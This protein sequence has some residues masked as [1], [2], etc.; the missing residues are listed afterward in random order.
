[1]S[2]SKSCGGASGDRHG[3]GIELREAT[4]VTMSSSTTGLPVSDS[5]AE[6]F[7]CGAE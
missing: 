6:A 1:M 5:D 7:E 4:A 2:A 3:I